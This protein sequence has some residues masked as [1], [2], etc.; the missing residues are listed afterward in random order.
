MSVWMI[1]PN[2]RGV[3]VTSLILLHIVI[4]VHGDDGGV[5]SVCP[6]NHY[7]LGED[8]YTCANNSFSISGSTARV[9]CK[10]G[11][12]YFGPDGWGCSR[13]SIGSFCVGGATASKCPVHYTS[14]MGSNS[15]SDCFCEMGRYLTY[16]GICE[17]CERLFWCHDGVKNVCPEGLTSPPGSA[18]Q[19][20]CTI[21]VTS[22]TSVG[23]DTSTS[24]GG[25]TSTSVGGDT[26]TS[27][28]DDDMTTTPTPVKTTTTT[29]PTK[30]TVASVSI[31]VF[32]AILFMRLAEFDTAARTAYIAG[33]AIALDIPTD[34]VELGSIR[35]LTGLRRLL[36]NTIAVETIATVPV[37]QL[38]SAL[39]SVQT[40][41]INNALNSSN[42]TMGEV[43]TPSSTTVCGTGTYSSFDN[44]TCISCPAGTYSGAVGAS[45]I[46]TCN[47]CPWQT[48]SN[49]LGAS[50][51]N[52][53][54][55]CDAGTYSDTTGATSY[56]TCRGVKNDMSS[57]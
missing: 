43:T 9:D 17:Q 44:S 56:A 40:E 15:S 57:C 22:S 4:I 54:T 34:S 26:S 29:A 18:Y 39:S 8:I 53:C 24:V 48:Y 55:T 50:S 52:T 46:S 7:C 32:T 14:I 47:K 38:E 37:D 20:D 1:T 13:C 27:V 49:T 33:V 25:D 51:N 19:T 28:G 36:T 23:G 5:C 6:L 10:C 35:A 41:N 45:T 2:L 30:D 42:I 31:V 3:L 11:S 21:D 16:T 12:G